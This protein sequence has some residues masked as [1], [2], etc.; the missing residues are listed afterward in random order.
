MRI[1]PLL[2]G[3]LLVACYDKDSDD[4]G[5]SGDGGATDGG[6]G[7]DD[8]GS[9][10]GGTDGGSG[11]GGSGDGGADGGTDGG[12]G[13]GGTDGGAGD[14]GTG[15]GGLSTDAS[16]PV[17]VTSDCVGTAMDDYQFR[18]PGERRLRFISVYGPSADDDKV[19]VHVT[20]DQPTV[21]VLSSYDQTAW[22]VTE[23]FPGTIEEIIVSSYPEPR[24]TIVHPDSASLTERYLSDALSFAIYE[25]KDQ[26]RVELIANAQAMT[27]L[28]L[29]SFHACFQASTFEVAPS[30]VWPDMEILPETDIWPTCSDSEPVDVIE[31]PDLSELVDTEACAGVVEESAWCLT[32]GETGFYAVGMDT[33]ETCTVL[34]YD[35][36]ETKLAFFYSMAISGQYAFLCSTEGLLHRIDLRDGSREVA[37]QWCDGVVEHDGGLWVLDGAA[38]RYDSL[39]QMRCEDPPA[40]AATGM[41]GARFGSFGDNL[42]ASGDSPGRADL[43]TLPDAELVRSLD[44]EDFNAIVS[45]IDQVDDDLVILNYTTSLQHWYLVYDAVD[46][47]FLWAVPSDERTRALTCFAGG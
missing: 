11:D 9:G 6:A 14:G 8:G 12:A 45:G 19:R 7:D 18:T 34:E 31:D 25:W 15:D 37:D 22:E 30:E 26:D 27:G 3:I 40:P 16:R 46:G 4:T 13:D 44:F 17:A 10:D 32:R 23:E 21:L 2:A 28:D 24:P 42:W 33:G 5:G 38:T 41:Y 29:A 20:D 36:H 35:W 47:T 1:A 43:Y 39:Y